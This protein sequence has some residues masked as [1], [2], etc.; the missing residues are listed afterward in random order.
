MVAR[1]PI[2][3]VAPVIEA[4]R[5][6]AKAAVDEP[7]TVSATVIRD[8]HDQLGAGVVLFDPDGTARPRIAMRPTAEL[9]R[10]AA[11]VRPDREGA[12]SFRV[13]SWSDPY[14]TSWISACANQTSSG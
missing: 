12:W 3:D 8:G 2:L 14:A 1:I 10:Y 11:T 9:D 4:G 5:Y 7:F 6:P 13:E